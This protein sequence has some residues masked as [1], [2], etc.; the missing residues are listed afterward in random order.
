MEFVDGSSLLK[1]LQERPF[2]QQEAVRLTAGLVSGISH[3][4]RFRVLHRDI[5]PANVMLAGL[6]PKIGDFGSAAVLAEGVE[7]VCASKHSALYVPPEGWL[8]DSTYTARSDVYQA[9]MVL[10][11]LV[12]G[13]LE[14]TLEHYVTKSVR[15]ELI[16]SGTR[17][18]GLDDFERSR[19]ADRGL[20]ELSSKHALLEYGRAPQPY[21]SKELRRLIR[22]A[23]A[24]DPEKRFASAEEFLAKLNVTCVPNWFPL[25]EGHFAPRWQGWDWRV[26]E[27]KKRSGSVILLTRSRPGSGAFRRPQ[28]QQFST[29]EECFDWVESSR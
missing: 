2:G 5:K 1:L 8:D 15:R 24:A 7:S 27:R 28:N 14:Y 11:E 29:L 18:E 26:E 21:L 4:H 10:Y 25:T 9:G 6:I 17:F 16:K 3:L 22:K 23:T 13:P 19:A 20:R 12:N